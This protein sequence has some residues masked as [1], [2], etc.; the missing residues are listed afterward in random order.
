MSK[1]PYIPDRGEAIWLDFSPRVGKE[2]SERRPALVLSKKS[3][4]KGLGGMA[5]VC[6]I[7]TRSSRNELEIQIPDGYTPSG[8]VIAHQVK[9]AD[10]VERKSGKAGHVPLDVVNRVSKAVAILAGYKG[11]D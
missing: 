6:P 10:L 5:L 9:M 1:R 11:E 3:M 8:T 4:N 2:Q 7:T